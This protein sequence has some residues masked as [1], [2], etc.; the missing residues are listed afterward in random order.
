MKELIAYGCKQLNR[1]LTQ[2]GDGAIETMS[3]DAAV[4]AWL[5]LSSIVKFYTNQL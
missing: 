2:D 4:F 1:E 5:R 3:V